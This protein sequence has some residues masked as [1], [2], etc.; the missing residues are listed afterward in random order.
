MWVSYALPNL[1][2]F[3]F[4]PQAAE[5]LLPSAEQVGFAMLYAALHGT[6]VLMLACGLFRRREFV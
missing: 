1:Y 5:G 2:L 4:R 6:V 3:N